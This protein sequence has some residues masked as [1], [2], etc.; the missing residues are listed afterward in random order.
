MKAA[1]GQGGGFEAM[2]SGLQLG[3]SDRA[4]G[5]N[6][7]RPMEPMKN[8]LDHLLFPNFTVRNRTKPSLGTWI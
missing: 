4:H 3:A 2:T 1:P 5:A 7:T 6:D 8:A